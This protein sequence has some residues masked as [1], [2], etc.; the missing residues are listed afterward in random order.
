MVAESQDRVFR[1]LKKM[2]RRVE[3]ELPG[4]EKRLRCNIT[5]TFWTTCPELRSAE[6]GHWMAARGDK[7]WRRG[8][9]PQYEAELIGLEDGTATIRIVG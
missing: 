2:L 3:I 8:C 4:H 9:P 6:I 5:R 7:P 1:P